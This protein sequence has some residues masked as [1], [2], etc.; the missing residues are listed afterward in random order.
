[1]ENDYSVSIRKADEI[2]SHEFSE[3]YHAYHS[4][5]FHLVPSSDYS[6]K[7]CINE[8][9]KNSLRTLVAMILSSIH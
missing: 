2:S 7:K 8:V 9:D 3:K 6:W 4:T 5:L 1:M